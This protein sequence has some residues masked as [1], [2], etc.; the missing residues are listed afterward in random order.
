[1]FFINVACLAVILHRKT[2]APDLVAIC[3]YSMC[4]C[5]YLLHVSYAVAHCHHYECAFMVRQEVFTA[6]TTCSNSNWASCN[7]SSARKGVASGRQ[8]SHACACVCVCHSSCTHTRC[9]A[10]LKIQVTAAGDKVRP[11]RSASDANVQGLGA[12]C[13]LLLLLGW[14]CQ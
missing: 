11:V 1:M 13:L 8:H 12:G 9:D 7:G 10:P 4:V 14:W 3:A 2:E 6:T 5:L